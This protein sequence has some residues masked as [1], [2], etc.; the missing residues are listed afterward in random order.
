MLSFLPWWPQ[1]LAGRA[2]NKQVTQ[3]HRQIASVGKYRGEIRWGR[4]IKEEGEP[5]LA[6]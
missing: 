5:S 6:G 1:A 2:V 4:G 3:I